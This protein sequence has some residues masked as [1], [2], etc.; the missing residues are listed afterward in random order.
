MFSVSSLSMPR[1]NSQD[2]GVGE[3]MK[4]CVC[5]DYITS[6]KHRNLLQH[7]AKIFHV[8]APERQARKMLDIVRMLPG[9]CAISVLVRDAESRELQETRLGASGAP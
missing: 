4:P 7:Q 8:A 9:C 5:A 6:I 1:W 3:E 2:L